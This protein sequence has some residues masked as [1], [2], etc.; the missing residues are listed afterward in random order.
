MTGQSAQDVQVKIGQRS[1]STSRL[2]LS[3]APTCPG[4]EAAAATCRG[5][6]ELR[7][8]IQIGSAFL[9]RRGDHTEDATPAKKGRPL[10]EV[11]FTYIRSTYSYI[12]KSPLYCDGDPEFCG[13][14]MG[15]PA[16]WADR[17]L[18]TQRPSHGVAKCGTLIGV[19]VAYAQVN[20]ASASHNLRQIQWTSIHS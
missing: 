20:A 10:V 9:A 13:A 1:L 17:P 18:D 8:A 5:R 12:P 7:T 3:S 14:R 11:I 6:R 19:G 2:S 15:S 4:T 16:I